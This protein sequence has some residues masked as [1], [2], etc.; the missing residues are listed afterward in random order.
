VLDKAKPTAKVRIFLCAL[1]LMGF[2]HSQTTVAAQQCV[3]LF[4]G[5]SPN[6]KGIALTLEQQEGIG[7][8]KKSIRLTDLGPSVNQ[9]VTYEG[10]DDKGRI[11]LHKAVDKVWHSVFTPPDNGFTIH[12]D[13]RSIIHILGPELAHLWGI[14]IQKNYA[15]EFLFI[16]SARRLKTTL[17][18]VNAVLRR[19]GKE[20]IS[21][22]PAEFRFATD[23]EILDLS[24]KKD[25]GFLSHFP[26]VDRDETGGP[27]LVV[28]EVSF[29]LGALVLPKT[30]I[31]RMNLVTKE[32]LR[33][34]KMLESAKDIA[35]KIKTL[36][37]EQIINDRSIELDFGTGNFV[38]Q[39]SQ[40]RETQMITGTFGIELAPYESIKAITD[41]TF[42][43]LENAVNNLTHSEMSPAEVVLYRLKHIL[44]LTESDG[45][46]LPKSFEPIVTELGHGR[47]LTLS[48]QD[49]APL[50]QLMRYFS[51]STAPTIP[52]ASAAARLEPVRNVAL[53]ILK[54][55]D[56]R[57]QDIIVA[58]Q[59]AL[60]GESR[61]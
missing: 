21:L 50:L 2:L 23:R 39:L 57:L 12:G 8:L 31:E 10:H 44:K 35:P 48:E 5:S 40:L 20:P 52:G 32:H 42:R 15:G 28:H 51:A 26:F 46:S 24:L 41:Y 16:P 17:K 3:G 56:Q 45:F 9:Q 43:R 29:H 38:G 13:P 58:T 6:K 37:I 11:I 33:F 59:I 49:R 1:S 61:P 27:A 36:L 22:L 34:I 55:L 19:M 25:D 7:R 53:N 47:Q 60:A 54:G 18:K 4:S 30:V 14:D